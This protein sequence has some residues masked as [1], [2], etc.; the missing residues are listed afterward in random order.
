VTFVDETSDV[1]SQYDEES[2]SR[3]S[4]LMRRTPD[5]EP[6]AGISAGTSH[7][8]HSLDKQSPNSGALLARIISPKRNLPDD[9]ISLPRLPEL[10]RSNSELNSTNASVPI[11]VLNSAVSSIY[12]DAPIWPLTDPSEAL[13]LRHFVQNLAIW[14][15]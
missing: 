15:R 14:V 1:A 5:H 3:S 9:H 6:G 11:E 13:L 10:S 8:L 2:S 12:S 7:M 4:E